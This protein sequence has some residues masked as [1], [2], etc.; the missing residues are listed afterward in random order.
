MRPT[1]L[2]TMRATQRLMSH[3]SAIPT[4]LLFHWQLTRV[5]VC[6]PPLITIIWSELLL[7]PWMARHL[8]IQGFGC[9]CCCPVL[10]GVGGGCDTRWLPNVR[11]EC[12]LYLPC[13]CPCTSIQ[14]VFNIIIILF[15]MHCVLLA[16]PPPSW[17]DRWFMPLRPK[18]QAIPFNGTETPSDCIIQ[19]R[20]YVS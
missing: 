17:H 13:P 14:T 10:L 2:T 6:W 19:Y 15:S 11:G 8:F 7:L 20:D 9:Y 12:C 1:Q 18:A 4:H 5:L 3:P 16:V